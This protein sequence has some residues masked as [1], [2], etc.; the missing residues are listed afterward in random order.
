MARDLTFADAVKI[1]GSDTEKLR[2]IDL[3][4]TGAIHAATATHRPADVIRVLRS[5]KLLADHSLD[6][7][8]RVNGV[9]K[10]TK[11]SSRH[12]V[13]VAAHTVV[14][15][16]AL[17]EAL[18]EYQPLFERFDLQRADKLR[19]AG[20]LGDREAAA[21]PA[22]TSPAGAFLATGIPWPSPAASSFAILE[23]LR[24]RYTEILVRVAG[25]VP[26]LAEW[27]QLDESEQARIRTLG[28]AREAARIAEAAGQRYTER[29]A[30][31]AGLRPEFFIWQTLTELQAAATER[32]AEGRALAR[33][34]ELLESFAAETG[35]PGRIGDRLAKAYRAELGRPLAGADEA[36]P[37]PGLTI[38]SVEQGYVD[39][40]FRAAV[41]DETS[42]RPADDWWWER[43]VR[44]R[45]DL[46]DFLAVHLCT[47]AASEKPTLVLGH[48]GAGK[49]LFA[50]VLTARAPHGAFAP[51]RVELRR[52]AANGGVLDQ[53]EE[54]M[55]ATLNETVSWAD[56]SRES[57][58]AGRI[59]LLVFDGLDELLQTWGSTKAD[60]LATVA[61]FQ[62]TE[63]VQERPVVAI[64]TSR[65]L[66]MTRAAIPRGCTVLRLEPFDPRRIESWVTAWNQWSGSAAPLE[67]AR[68]MRYPALAAQPLLLLMLALYNAD[69]GHV[70]ESDSGE[71][72][73]VQG[74]YEGLVRQF[75][76]REVLKRAASGE[77]D[78][79][80]VEHL[81]DAEVDLLALVAFGMFNRGTQAISLAELNDDLRAL[82]AEPAQ[83][84]AGDALWSQA[85]RVVGRFYFIHESQAGSVG[86]VD[87]RSYEFLHATFGE[88]L[89]AWKIMREAT[90]LLAL[91]RAGGLRHGEYDSLM[92]AVLSFAPLTSRG[93]VIVFLGASAR[94][95]PAADREALS[96]LLIELFRIALDPRPGDRYAA[97]LPER[98]DA[99][100][101]Y[102][103]WRL[104]ILI[105]LLA[106]RESVGLEELFDARGESPRARDLWAHTARLWYACLLK[107]RWDEAL[108][109]IDFTGDRVSLAAP[110]A[111]R[112]PY[113]HLAQESALL[114]LSWDHSHANL[115]EIVRPYQELYRAVNPSA[116][117][118][119]FAVAELL[120][121]LRI[122]ASLPGMSSAE[123]MR[124]LIAYLPEA[125]SAAR[126]LRSTLLDIVAED[127]HRFP[128][129]LV[130]RALPGPASKEEPPHD[131]AQRLKVFQIAVALLARRRLTRQDRRQLMAV[132][133]GALSG[134]LA[135]GDSGQVL[136]F[137]SIAVDT[138]IDLAMRT[139]TIAAALG[140]VSADSS[141]QTINDALIV[142]LDEGQ[143]AWLVEVGL[144]LLCT[145]PPD[146]GALVSRR[147]MDQL[148]RGVSGYAS[149]NP[150]GPAILR[151]LQAARRSFDA[152][153]SL[154]DRSIAA[155]LAPDSG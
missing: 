116:D 40:A 94:A 96:T 84:G 87:L 8:R 6:L 129:G 106:V 59:P 135:A 77:R 89:V 24:A 148:Y 19:F 120:A 142:A 76:R 69:P 21:V 79:D 137:A 113:A 101:R 25:F 39:P 26:G 150:D 75:T 58:E 107:P 108:G 55:R 32:A 133:H 117:G 52:V 16:A 145:A 7:M 98:I 28:T 102:A 155:Y 48:P 42:M 78:P 23:D 132:V 9:L 66:V 119:S 29:L 83:A 114:E 152:R 82:V 149:N 37:G 138:D 47:G 2:S 20:G 50:K 34:S 54:A 31:L 92:Y 105:L 44:V 95:L 90:R 41:Y 61:E 118:R 86:G 151:R 121:A 127:P 10:R 46:A 12:E 49:S 115:V 3:I 146:A 139:K 103:V 81:V 91:R 154:L 109:F 30:E 11:P 153:Q 70:W 62:R 5:L 51:L 60:F 85:Q 144:E 99:P 36:D 136:R 130:L 71:P 65:T 15:I 128:L 125:D 134:A 88:Y 97:Y 56:F 112:T 63:A 80:R 122:G 68:V 141:A 104:N 140:Q 43:E 67:S 53:I 1:L 72:L 33:I 123:M 124:A 13:L 18:A 14:A 74:L 126:L 38:P 22:R 4:F 35:G 111:V 73:E 17:F 93:Q 131:A 100:S 27:D 110:N 45:E 147:T 64:V 57:V 143:W